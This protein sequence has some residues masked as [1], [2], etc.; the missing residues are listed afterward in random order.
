[1][2]GLNA[3]RRSTAPISSATPVSRE[4]STWSSPGSRL[5]DR[6]CEDERA[7]L[8]GLGPP[9]LGTQTV[10]SGSASTVGPGRPA[11]R[12]GS[13]RSVTARGAGRRAVARS[14]TTS[15]GVSGRS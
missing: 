2:F 4:M 3:A 6:S 5:T 7:G 8:A 15:I 1:M 13:G 11:G 9:A 12:L 10:Q 14:A